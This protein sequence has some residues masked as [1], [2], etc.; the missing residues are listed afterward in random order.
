MDR[1]DYYRDLAFVRY[2]PDGS[3]DTAFGVN[4]TVI[5]PLSGY[6]IVPRD[7]ELQQ[8]G[9][10]VA[11]VSGTTDFVLTRYNDDGSLDSTFGSDGFVV[12]DVSGGSDR[13]SNIFLQADGKIVV[14]GTANSYSSFVRYNPDGSLDETFGSGGKLITDFTSSRSI[15]FGLQKDGKPLI[16]WTFSNGT[17]DDFAVTRYNEDGTLDTT[18]GVSGRVT[19]SIGTGYD[20]TYYECTGISSD[21]DDDAYCFIATAAY[22]SYLDPHVQALRD[23]RDRHLLSH[24][25][26]R[27]LMG[28]YYRYSPPAASFITRHESLR[29]ATRLALTPLVFT[30]KYPKTTGLLGVV[31]LGMVSVVWSR[32]RRIRMARESRPLSKE[33]RI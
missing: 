28:L 5:A 9:K 22:G 12:T 11:A 27:M 4:G 17:D 10:I 19:T 30:I 2:H 24:S 31:V 1:G 26:G 32:K 7:I 6:Y 16:A 23:F 14:A 25:V 8:D 3:L 15:R 29:I 18:F 33:P 13:A 21:S 20:Y